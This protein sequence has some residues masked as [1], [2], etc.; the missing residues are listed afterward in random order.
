MADP[1]ARFIPSSAEDVLRLRVKAEVRKR[2]RA[3]RK[4]TPATACGARSARIVD[5]LSALAVVAQARAVALFWPIEERH[6]VDLRALDGRLRER[7]VRVAYPALDPETR[8]MT[9]RFV[10]EV[11]AM[12]EEGFGFREPSARDPEVRPDELDVIV[13]PA[14]AVDPRGHRLGYGAGDYD[15]TLVR[16]APPAVAVAVA[17]DF[18]LVPETPNTEGD[19]AVAWIVTDT[20]ELRA[21]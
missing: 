19:V 12:Q 13:V 14:L 1:R 5:R 7:G 9:F 15:R 17:Y 2:M 16:F 18:Q 8:A 11:N 3:L 4:T 6:E 20:R 21:E 10:A